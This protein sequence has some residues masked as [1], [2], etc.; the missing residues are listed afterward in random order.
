[1]DAPTSRIYGRSIPS[2]TI[3][4]K[5]LRT[6]KLNRASRPVAAVSLFLM[7]SLLVG[8]GSIEGDS[9]NP[10]ELGFEGVWRASLTRPE[11][12]QP[13]DEDLLWF[14]LEVSR[15]ED[16]GSLSAWAI[17][18]DERVAFT[19]AVENGR[20]VTFFSD[21]YDSEIQAR[22]SQDGARL[23]GGWRKTDKDGD[24]QMVFRAQRGAGRFSNKT[25][26]QLAELRPG[27]QFGG[28]WTATFVDEDGEFPARGLLEQTG[29][30]LSGTF[31][32]ATGDYRYLDGEIVTVDGRDELRLSAF[33]GAHAFLFCAHFEDEGR[34]SGDFW[35]RDHYHA[36]WTARP[37][38]PDDQLP[39]PFE[40]IGLSNDEGSFSF[41]FPDVDGRVVANTDPSF[42]GKVVLVDIFGSWCPNCNDSADY[43]AS[44]DR[45]Y[46]D[47]GLAIVGLGFEMTGDFQR[48]AE[49]V[50]RYGKRHSITFPLL[51]AGTSDK[52]E[53]A[54]AL[55][56]IDVLLSFP[57]KIFID[58][59]G[60]VREIYS[61]Y[62]GPSTGEAYEQMKA[63][64]DQLIETLL[65]EDAAKTQRSSA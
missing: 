23:D 47:R 32:T 34:L 13:G 62:D 43:L 65:A 25:R 6:G 24:A 33:D 18:G 50:K 16:G 56:D 42:S 15:S 5:G 63:S 11:L 64:I 21:G 29:R 45:R 35:S 59:R 46:R 55:T 40:Q 39:N 28:V 26:S 61:G 60:K 57:T 9:Q 4:K 36:T 54:E 7:A 37:L 10:G 41:S 12:Q 27:S 30:Y 31:R 58:R 17:N 51:V 22:L 20:S 3:T 44:L 52:E 14:G 1:M 49:L 38:E 2:R 53:A 8:C 48:D 19:R